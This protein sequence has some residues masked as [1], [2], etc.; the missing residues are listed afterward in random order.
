MRM[1]KG[2]NALRHLYGQVM[3]IQELADVSSDCRILRIV[4]SSNTIVLQE[5]T[6]FLDGCLVG[7]IVS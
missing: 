4:F 5:F 3:S 2:M 7:R 1:A 6:R